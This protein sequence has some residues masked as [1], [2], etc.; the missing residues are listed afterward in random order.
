MYRDICVLLPIHQGLSTICLVRVTI[1]SYLTILESKKRL[2][3]FVEWAD[4][5]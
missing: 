4:K 2:H 3:G 1:R 5:Q